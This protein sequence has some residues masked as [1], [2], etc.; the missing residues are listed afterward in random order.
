MTCSRS[1][2]RCGNPHPGSGQSPPWCLVPPRHHWLSSSA[3][4]IPSSAGMR[5][6]GEGGEGRWEATCLGFGQP[7]PLNRTGATQGWEREPQQFLGMGG[8]QAKGSS[9]T[10]IPQSMKLGP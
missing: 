1:W 9:R 2:R 6:L 7:E 8:V 3:T 4:S 5:P 10:E